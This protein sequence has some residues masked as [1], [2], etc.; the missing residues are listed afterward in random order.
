MRLSFDFPYPSQAL[1]KRRASNK[2]TP[3]SSC[4]DI[5]IFQE[6]RSS[7]LYMKSPYVLVVWGETQGKTY[8]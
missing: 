1:T 6:I 2:P 3:N 4:N 7:P 8:N 5:D